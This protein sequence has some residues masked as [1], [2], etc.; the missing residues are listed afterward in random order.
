MGQPNSCSTA[1]LHR[2]VAV[3]KKGSLV[4][5]N[6]ARLLV[7]LGAAQFSA[8]SYEEASRELCHASDLRPEDSTPY[9]F[10]GKMDVTS[11]T[12]FPCISGKLSRFL[13]NQPTNALAN[14]YFAMSQVK[15]ERE[16]KNSADLHEAQTLLEKAVMLD[17]KLGEAYLQLGILYA[18]QGARRRP[19]S[20]TQ[21][22]LR[23]RRLSANL[24]TG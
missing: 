5:P 10:L 15:K 13:K 9:L 1:L 24:I 12:S 4:H 19:S 22:R 20:R 6:S 21:K 2:P 16:A 18:A 14:Y 11:P 3:F 23:Q 8:G 7:G 17:P